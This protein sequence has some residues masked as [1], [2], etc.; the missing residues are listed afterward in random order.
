MERTFHTRPADI[1]I[2]RYSTAHTIAKTIPGG[3]NAG[4]R[5]DGYHSV[6]DGSWTSL[7]MYPTA[8]DNI[9]KNNIARKR[10]IKVFY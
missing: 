1:P 7:E 10:F 8:N 2:S 5:S 6:I 9:T 4:F 3:V